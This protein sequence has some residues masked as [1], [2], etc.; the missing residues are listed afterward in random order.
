MSF[1]TDTKAE[2]AS[3]QIKKKCCRRAYAAGLL[4]DADTDGKSRVLATCQSLES[5]QTA[6]KAIASVFGANAVKF[7]PVGEGKGFTFAVSSPD[8]AELVSNMARYGI[9]A[10]VGFSCEE[11][12]GSFMR[13]LFIAS[14][15]LTSPDRQYHLEFTLQNTERAEMLSAF[16]S[17]YASP[18]TLRHRAGRIGLIYKSS[19]KIEDFLSSVGASQAYFSLL[20]GKIEREIRNDINRSTNCMTKNIA[21]A[22]AASRAQTEALEVLE[23]SGECDKLPPE[24]RET[25]QL[26]LL[27]PEM[28]LSELGARHCPPISKSGVNHRMA[29][30]MA[31]A[32]GIKKG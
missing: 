8:A 2:L 26:R 27:Y 14:G 1:S 23:S 18:P 29:K 19:A 13:G 16:L 17:E 11:C 15:S 3:L 10:M 5:A 28:P 30:L 12:A 20:N 6:Q 24:L 7:P 4:F 31:I 25:A 9:D 32:E 22:V 21:K